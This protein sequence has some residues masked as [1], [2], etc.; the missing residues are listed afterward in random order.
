MRRWLSAAALSCVT[1]SGSVHAATQPLKPCRVAGFRQSVLCGVVQRALDPARPQGVQID[2]HYL[3]LPALAR[4][5]LPDPV[6][7]LAGGPGQSAIA[8]APMVAGQLARLNNRRDLVFVDQRGTGASAPLMCA[9]DDPHTRLAQSLDMT[10][11]EQQT[12][13]CL[14][15]LQALPYGDLRFFTTHLATQDLDAVRQSLGAA[16][17]NLMGV[18]YGTRAALDYQRQ[19][20]E[21][22]RRTVLDSVAPPD[23]ALTASVS[24]DSQTALHALLDSCEQEPMCAKTYPR[25]RQ[26]W[27]ALLAA[28]PQTTT[29]TH[30]LTGAQES[31]RLTRENVLGSVRGPLYLPVL[32]SALPYAIT[33]AEQGRFDALFGL[34]GL[35]APQGRQRLAVGMHMSV[36]CAE[37][38]PRT[39]HT[40]DTPGVDF[41]LEFSQFYSDTCSYWPRAAVPPAFYT[42]KPVSSPTLVLSG[43]LDPVTPTRHGARVTQAL[44]AQA[45]HVVVANAGHG[46]ANLPCMRDVLFRFFDATDDTPAQAL[47]ATCAAQ[48]PRPQ[49]FVPVA[50]SGEARP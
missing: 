39:G 49:A 48:I 26:R 11:R 20:P 44:G 13:S 46:V 43:G 37:D 15:Q 12:R 5:K 35:L 18:S 21:A 45:R 34:G 25:L 28:L 14:S 23:M 22:V 29:L 31:V 7:F 16:R 33:Q 8:V 9:D 19:F 10:R 38:Q 2:V 42:I 3:V 1:L 30:P 32:A 6:F 40:G 50:L 36:V 17:I 47:D 4:R 24:M 41:G 27:T